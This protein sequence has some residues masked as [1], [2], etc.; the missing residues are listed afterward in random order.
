MWQYL[1]LQ[2][3]HVAEVVPCTI[4]KWDTVALCRSRRLKSMVL[5]S[6]L[7]LSSNAPC[8]YTPLPNM[9]GVQTKLFLPWGAMQRGGYLW[10]K[11]LCLSNDGLTVLYGPWLTAS[12]PSIMR[13]VKSRWN[14]GDGGRWHSVSNQLPPELYCLFFVPL[15][16][17]SDSIFI[18]WWFAWP[19]CRALWALLKATHCPF[20]LSCACRLIFSSTH[21]QRTLTGFT[22]THT[23]TW[24]TVSSP[25]PTF[26]MA[27]GWV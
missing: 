15:D 26:L 16:L 7:G 11:L 13:K 8:Q 2:G 12:K 17:Y 14:V 18:D 20:M 25:F 1:H 24:C 21:S 27:A 6:V 4:S 19:C 10:Q 5:H 23:H 9:S 22:H 3:L